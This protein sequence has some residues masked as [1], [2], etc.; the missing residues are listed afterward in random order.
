[1]PTLDDAIARFAAIAMSAELSLD[2]E[3]FDE[4]DRPGR[5]RRRARA[6]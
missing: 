6:R 1:M 3:A 5:R 2:G 4:A